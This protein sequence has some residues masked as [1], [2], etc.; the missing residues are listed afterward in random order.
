MRLLEKNQLN[1]KDIHTH[2]MSYNP[3]L[4]RDNFLM[5]AIKHYQS[6]II[7]GMEEF[8]EDLKYLRYVKRWVNTFNQKGFIKERIVLN[9]IVVLCN[10]FTPQ[11]AVKMLFYKI[12][13]DGWSVLK[14]FCL[15]LKIMPQ[16]LVGIK[17]SIIFTDEIPSNKQI[18]MMLEKL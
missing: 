2:S 3:K 18:D 1:G 9:H 8:H 6:P 16:K 14:S 11:H 5:Y 7:V 10:M 12:D 13:E 17:D 4:T 15:Y